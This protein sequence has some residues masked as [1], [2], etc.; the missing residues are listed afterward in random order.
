LSVLP[1]LVAG[2]AGLAAPALAL[3]LLA[4]ASTDAVPLAG[5]AAILALGLMGAGM[6]GAAA[7]GRLAAGIIL[8]MASGAG[9]LTLALA[10]GLPAAHEPFAVALAAILAS[11]SFAARGALY[12][13]SAAHRGWWIALGVV[14]GEAAMLA[15][16][17]TMPGAVPDWLLALLPAQW[18]SAAMRT[19]LGGVGTLA[20]SSE[21]LALAGT[22]GA[23]L[24]V[25]RLWP[26]R[27][28][29]LVMFT[30]WLALSALV[31]HRPAPEPS[32]P[33]ARPAIDAAPAPVAIISADARIHS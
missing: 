24:L 32:G 20:A 3:F 22:A 18:A 2:V 11:L 13:R 8:A 9:L 4:R 6:I 15:T 25:A 14:A 16:A 1:W 17:A 28:P 29:Y 30:A 26:Q 23:T 27:W 21:L 33:A 7:A 5:G 31:L 12:A 10:T 19:A